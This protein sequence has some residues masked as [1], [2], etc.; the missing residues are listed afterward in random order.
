MLAR[1]KRIQVKIPSGVDNGSRIRVAG[2]GQPGIGGGPRGDLFLVISVK[3]DSIYERKGDDL[4]AD[5]DVDLVTAMLG[6]EVPL[7]PPDG[8]KLILTTPPET[9][10]RPL[11]P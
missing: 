2:E 1:N 5:I 10:N 4:Y 8:P 11:F 3:S 9:Q 7:P 6:G